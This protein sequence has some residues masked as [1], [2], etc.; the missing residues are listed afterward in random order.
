[1]EIGTKSEFLVERDLKDLAKP[2]VVAGIPAFNEELTIAKVVLNAQK[3]ADIVV[4]C[5]DGSKDATAEIAE[6]LGAVVIRHEQNGGYGAAL[7]SLF[8]YAKKLKADVLVTLDSDGQHDPL[9]IPALIKPIEDGSA[10][11]VLGSR[12]MSEA[13]TADMPKYRRFGIKFITKLSNGYA[14]NP[15]S[16]AQSGFRAYN[17]VAIEK[18]SSFSED[19]M[20]ASIELLQAVNR[21]GLNVSEVPISCK[22]AD[23]VGVETSTKNPVRQGV[24]LIMAIAKLIVEERPLTFLG[25]PGIVFLVVGALFGVWMLELYAAE[26]RIVTNAALAAIGFLFL[27]CFMISTAI[28]LYAITRMSKKINKC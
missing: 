10:D 23:S 1:L 6:R 24:G 25:S 5:D 22:Y 12:F 17:K 20:G 21:S 13:G 14:K 8:K 3:Y 9:E 26:S 4:V 15:I 7:H 2:L 27:G 19:G 28:T 18:L 16:D 11:V